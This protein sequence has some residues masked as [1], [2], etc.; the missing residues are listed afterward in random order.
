MTIRTQPP[1]AGLPCP[2]T[3][4]GAILAMGVIR[5]IERQKRLD[6]LTEESVST[7]VSSTQEKTRE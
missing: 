4:L 3:I 7:G 6:N 2:T 5:L 1:S